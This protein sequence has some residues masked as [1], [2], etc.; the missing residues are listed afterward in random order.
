[1]LMPC[2]MNIMI[3]NR[4]NNSRRDGEMDEVTLK[5]S[6]TDM[7]LKLSVDLSLGLSLETLGLMNIF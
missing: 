2:I 4:K 1:M 6:V 7:G 3:Q 5:H